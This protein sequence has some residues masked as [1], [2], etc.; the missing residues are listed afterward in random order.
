MTDATF[1]NLVISDDILKT[2][3]IKF[4]IESQSENT[5]TCNQ[6][7]QEAGTEKCS[8]KMNETK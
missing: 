8:I 3:E 1:K 2:I 5:A 4:R 7:G 6:I